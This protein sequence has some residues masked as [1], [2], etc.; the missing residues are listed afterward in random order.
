MSILSKPDSPVDLSALR[1]PARLTLLGLWAERIT[2]AFWPLWTVGLVIWTVLAMGVLSDLPLEAAWGA[3]L[4]GAGALIWS[5]IFAY[6]RFSAPKYADALERIDLTMPG[7][8]VTAALDTQAIGASDAASQEIWHAHKARMQARL[9]EARAVDPDLRVSK[10]DPY[11]LRYV[12]LL[13]FAL[14]VGFG[15]LLRTGSFDD[16]TPGLGGQA[17]AAGPAWEIWIEPPAY[18]GKPSLYLNDVKVSELDVPVGS[19]LTVRLYG[20]VGSLALNETVSGAAPTAEGEVPQTAFTRKVNRSGTVAIEGGDEDKAWQITALEDSLPTIAADG[21]VERKVDGE[22]AL[23][24][25]ATDD[26][27]VEFGTATI[28]LDLAS[29]D[30]R[31]GL[32]LEPEP[33]ESIVLDLPMPISGDRADFSE[34]VIENLSEHPLATL[35]VTIDLQVTDSSE[36]TNAPTQVQTEL[37]GRRFFQP[38]ANALIEQRRDLLW[39]RDN[40]KRITQILRTITYDP[41]DYFPSEVAFLTVRMAIT[42][43][44]LAREFDQITDEK[45]AE[46]AEMLWRA[47]TLIEDGRL[48]DARERLRAAQERLS[49]AMEQGATSEEIAELMQELSEAMRDLMEQL[50]QEGQEGGEQQQAQNQQGQEITGDQLQEMLDEIQRLMEEGRTEEAQALLD[51]LMEMIENMQVTQGQQGQGQPSPGE[52][53]MEGLQDTLREQQ[54][55]SDEAFRDLQ[56]QFNPGAQAGE[57]QG[58][59]GR[60]GGQGR[61]QSH[62]NSPGQEGE[63]G[64]NQQAEGEGGGQDQRGEGSLA[65]RQQ[66]L[67]DELNRQ[68]RNLPGQGSPEG[69][70]AREALD[71]AGEAMERAEDALRNDETAEALG[72]QSDAME[73]LREGMRNLGE[74]MAQQQQ[75]GQG[76]QGQNAGRAN[77]QRQDPL[78]REQGTNGMI[79]SEDNMLQGEDARRRARDLRDEIRRRSGEQER[80]EIERDYLRR[81]LDQ[82]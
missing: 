14:A 79:G 50:A 34:V 21:E 32:A 75:D 38:I 37:P 81:L 1:T 6:R 72:A 5:L 73:A 3:T 55:L 26:Y 29:V 58:N 18:T 46:I 15:S 8:P 39:N 62:E 23:P 12:A 76:Q 64:E 65:D 51:Q 22:M 36:Q 74:A 20:Q 63:G 44:E 7:R 56:E 52:Q 30:R 70:A 35:P 68:Q 2:H 54:G 48:D 16:L 77:N 47:A 45:Q 67:R 19:D 43:L 53:A 59:E 40:A 49:E 57:N 24:F 31:Y 69:E 17:I 11:A 71:R 13:F 27:G 4:A 80:P 60:N 33:Q 10:A 66:A 82:F 78:G 41:D 61:G 28:S 25:R 42:R 9:A